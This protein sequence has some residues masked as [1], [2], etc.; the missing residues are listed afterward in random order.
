MGGRLHSLKLSAPSKGVTPA[1]LAVYH[2][3]DV[4]N[5]KGC[6]GE[7]RIERWG[8][9][10]LGC[11]KI[12]NRPAIWDSSCDDYCN[13]DLKKK[14]W[15]EVMESFAR[16]V[17]ATADKNELE[18]GVPKNRRITASPIRTN[19]YKVTG[20]YFVSGSTLQKRWKNLRG[21]FTRDLRRQKK[22][23]SGSE[24]GLRKSEYIFFNKLQ[25]LRKVVAVRPNNED[26]V[27]HDPNES[28]GEGKNENVSGSQRRLYESEIRKK[29]KKK[30]NANLEM[31][32][33]EENEDRMFLLSLLQP[34]KSI[35]ANKKSLLKFS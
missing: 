14:Y 19:I 18:R 5:T 6:L 3:Y 12:Q 32:Q 35:R 26:A 31:I 33:V 21:S 20:K 30:K 9:I 22:T 4:A 17:I 15:E 23:K 13:R 16:E 2:S 34:L 27:V 25:F 11:H 10:T 28:A 8:R 24:T 7:G 29:K 1:R